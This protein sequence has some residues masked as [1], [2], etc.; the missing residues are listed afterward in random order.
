MAAMRKHLLT[1]LVTLFCAG[2]A[3]AQSDPQQPL[4]GEFIG[5]NRLIRHSPGDLSVEAE[6]LVFTNGRVVI[7]EFVSVQ[8]SAFAEVPYPDPPPHLRNRDGF[9]TELRRVTAQSGGTM[10]SHGQP[11]TLVI[12][13]YDYPISSVDVAA[14]TSDAAGNTIVCGSSGY[15]PTPQQR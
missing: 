2:A 14:L 13:Q 10:C 3:Y 12:L 6:R 7:T 5:A 15:L 1:A 4:V 9:W 11:A 8:H